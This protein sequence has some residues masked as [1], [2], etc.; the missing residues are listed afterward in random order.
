M[1][2]IDKILEFIE[3][4]GLTKNK[5]DRHLVDKRSFM[6]NALRTEGYTLQKIGEI[7]GKNHATIL[8]GIK[9]HKLF[10][11]HNDYNY[12][13]NTKEYRE[14]LDTGYIQPRSLQDDVLRCTNTTELKLIQER[15]IMGKYI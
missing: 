6:Y 13:K 12:D 9:K 7:F 2:K 15:L 8:N 10:T 11:K 3:K 1:K 14:Y 4:D 5:R